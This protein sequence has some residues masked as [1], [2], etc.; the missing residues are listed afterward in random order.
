M[1]DV[2]EMLSSQHAKEKAERRQCLLKIIEN[3]KFLVCQGLALRGDGKEEDSNFTQLLELCAIDN[4]VLFHWVQRSTDKYTS[5]QVQNEMLK[6]MGL[7]VLSDIGD[8]RRSTQFLTIMV[9]ETTIDAANQEQ[10]VLCL[11]WMDDDFAAHEEMIGLYAVA[12]TH[13]DVLVAVVEDVLL[14]LSLPLSKLKGQCY[15]GASSMAGHRSGVATQILEKEPNA[16]YTHCYGQALNL[17]CGDS[18]KTCAT[19]KLRIV[20]GARDYKTYQE[21]TKALLPIQG[22]ETPAGTRNSRSSHFM[23]HPMVC[24]G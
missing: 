5:P 3:V 21:V 23:P 22:I 8:A 11:H 24:P 6:V 7:A 13:A 10:V 14:R 4:P 20:N 19:V 9:D 12:S 16:L 18:M 1:P 17:A 2:G 15:D